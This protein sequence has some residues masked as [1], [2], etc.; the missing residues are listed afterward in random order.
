MELRGKKHDISDAIT[1]E[2]GMISIILR[3]WKAQIW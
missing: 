2:V 3:N 1:S